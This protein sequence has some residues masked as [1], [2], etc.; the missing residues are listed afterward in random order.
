MDGFTMSKKI[1]FIL[2]II[3][4]ISMVMMS[5]C[6]S[7]TQLT[8]I[9]KEGIQYIHELEKV[10]RDVYLYFYDKWG[11]SVQNVISG[12]EQNHMDIMKA[13]IDKYNL[14]DTV[15]SNDHGYFNNGDL[16]QLYNSLIES[17]SSSEVDAL[18]TAAMI[19]EYDIVEIRKYNINTDKEDIVSAYN[20]LT[21][22]SENHLRVFV[23]KLKDNMVEYQPQ[24]LSQQDF[25]QIIGTETTGTTTTTTTVSTSIGVTFSELAVKGEQSYN[26]N[27]IN[28]HGNSLST[29]SGSSATLSRYQNAQNLLEKI[30]TMPAGGK[31]AQWE[32]LSY[33]LLEH[34][35]VSGDAIF[36]AD[37]LSQIPLSQ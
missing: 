25:N 37:T 33:L 16:Q 11:T 3:M 14:D 13:L 9:E 17:G 18:S 29:M 1:N 20:E 7:S 2:S 8:D 10:A 27:C 21:T 34:Y 19:E 35:W 23:A 22:G 6:S 24:Y 32:I 5:S 36:N 15:E 4:V 30:A 28:C 31:Q 26:S 12:S